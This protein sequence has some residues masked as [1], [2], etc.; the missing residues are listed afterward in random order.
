MVVSDVAERWAS[1]LLVPAPLHIQSTKS[2]SFYFPKH[3]CSTFSLLLL[4]KYSQ[5]NS[6]QVHDCKTSQRF[7]QCIATSAG[8]NKSINVLRCAKKKAGLNYV[9]PTLLAK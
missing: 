4:S 5:L 7:V 8:E 2:T 9:L 3:V 6:S 1:S